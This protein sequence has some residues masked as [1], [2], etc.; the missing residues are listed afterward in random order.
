M[1]CTLPNAAYVYQPFVATVQLFHQAIASPLRKI[2][3]AIK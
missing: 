3:E 1:E 2:T